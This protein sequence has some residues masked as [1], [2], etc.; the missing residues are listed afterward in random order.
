MH[1]RVAT[2]IQRAWKGLL[3]LEQA[4]CS[5][6]VHLAGFQNDIILQFLEV[7]QVVRAGVRLFPAAA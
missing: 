1:L 2:R 3:K 6:S 4:N 5:Y 7:V